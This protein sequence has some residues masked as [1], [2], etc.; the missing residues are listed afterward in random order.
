MRVSL[1]EQTL[2]EPKL[3]PFRGCDALRSQHHTHVSLQACKFMLSV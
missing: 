1:E 2:W 3:T